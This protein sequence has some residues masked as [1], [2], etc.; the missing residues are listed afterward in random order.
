MNI[1]AIDASTKSSGWAIFEDARLLGYGCIQS[2]S[3]DLIKR[4]Y[5]MKDG[6]EKILNEYKIDKIILEEVRPEQGLQ[7]LKT[8]KALLYLQAAIAFLVHEKFNKIS[9]EYVYPSEWRKACGI[10]TGRGVK[11][12]SLKPLDI[13]FVRNTYNIVVN[14]DVADAIGIGHAYVNTINNEINWE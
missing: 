4:I 2:A 3:A 7:N 1:L 11:R 5:V 12:E 14:D 6:I 8:H 13:A 10:K 9:I